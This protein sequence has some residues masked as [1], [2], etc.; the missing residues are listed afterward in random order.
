MSAPAL[1]ASAAATTPQVA[2]RS[3]GSAGRVRA[4]GPPQEARATPAAA[5]THA[6][7]KPSERDLNATSPMTGSSA[8]RQYPS[9]ADGA[10]TFDG[11]ALGVNGRVVTCAA[12]EDGAGLLVECLRTAA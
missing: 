4:F 3:I 5:R 2:A 11:L 1:R 8:C 10:Q 9:H 7:R 12:A 6:P